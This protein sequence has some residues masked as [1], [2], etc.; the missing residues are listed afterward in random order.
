[1]PRTYVLFANVLYVLSNI[2]SSNIPVGYGRR[3]YRF[4]QNVLDVLLTDQ[5]EALLYRAQ[6]NR[7]MCVQRPKQRGRRGAGNK[8]AILT[9]TQP[10]QPRPPT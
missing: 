6:T 2:Y 1:M 8:P 10:D 4:C 7:A 5:N 3:T 9:K